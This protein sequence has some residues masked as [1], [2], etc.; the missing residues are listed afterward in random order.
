MQAQQPEQH[1]IPAGLLSALGE[2]IDGVLAQ[3]SARGDPQATPPW[4]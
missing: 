1:A 2:Q 4:P 3:E